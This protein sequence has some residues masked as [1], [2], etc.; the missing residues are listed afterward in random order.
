MRI[1][2]DRKIA[3]AYSKGIPLVKADE[4]YAKRFRELYES[5]EDS[6]HES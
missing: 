3:V 6:V 2:F 1:P 5:I 4:G